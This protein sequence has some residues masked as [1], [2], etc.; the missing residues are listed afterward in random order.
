MFKAGITQ[1]NGAFYY[2]SSYTEKQGDRHDF[3]K[4]YRKAVDFN[5]YQLVRF[6]KYH[7]D[8]GYKVTSFL[9]LSKS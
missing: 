4:D 9:D 8:L 7:E 2:C 1:N 5:E 3:S 6:T